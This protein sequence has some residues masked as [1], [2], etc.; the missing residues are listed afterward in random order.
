MIL[1]NSRG[2]CA[3]RGPRGKW[4][5]RSQR[6]SRS[7]CSWPRARRSHCRQWSDVYTRPCRRL[8]RPQDDIT[9][10]GGLDA[11]SHK[12]A[13]RARRARL[14]LS[15]NATRR[16]IASNA[17]ANLLA[18][19][20][21]RV[22]LGRSLTSVVVY[23]QTCPTCRVGLCRPRPRLCG[24]EWTRVRPRRSERRWSL[25]RCAVSV[26]ILIA[27][28]NATANSTTVFRF[29]DLEVGCN[30]FVNVVP[31]SANCNTVWL[32]ALWIA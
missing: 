22:N 3:R 20:L 6:P 11:L 10:V 2:W 18:S 4:L 15:A 24:L 29:G 1:W 14:G 23:T 5:R 12:S 30:T 31:S 8:T 19:A 21:Q 7:W 32:S 27:P 17:T 25:T 13:A 16:S 9:D 28:L 26:K